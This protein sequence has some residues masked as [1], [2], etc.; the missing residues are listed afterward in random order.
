M[1]SC[2][3]M[4][5]SIRGIRG[6][7]EGKKSRLYLQSKIKKFIR[8][9]CKKIIEKAVPFSPIFRSLGHVK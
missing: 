2:I 8:W 3:Q 7:Y 5:K 6:L 9:H 4:S 1:K